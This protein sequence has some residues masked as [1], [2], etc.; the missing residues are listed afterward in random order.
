MTGRWWSRRWPAAWSRD[1]GSSRRKYLLIP[2]TK[3][4]ANAFIK[5]CESGVF[6][7]I[8][9]DWECVEDQGITVTAVGQVDAMELAL[10]SGDTENPGKSR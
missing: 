6:D 2:G 8:I 3:V 7:G 10:P 9:T 5:V 4:G 1:I